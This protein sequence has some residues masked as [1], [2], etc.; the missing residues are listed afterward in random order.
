MTPTELVAYGAKKGLAALALTDHD[1]IDG[2][3]EA[4]EAGKRCGIEVIPGI[5]TTTVVD[6]CDVHIVGLFFDPRQPGIRSQVAEMAKSRDD[7]NYAMVRQLEEAGIDIH[8]ADFSR[9]EG[10]AIA[11]AHVAGILMERGYASNL[12]E[13]VAKYMARGTVGYVRRRTPKPA[14]VVEV[15]HQAGGLAIIAH[16]NQI[17]RKD[18]AHGEAVCRSIIEAGA[19]GLE[20]L[21]SEYDEVWRGRAEALRKEY[22]LLASGGSD[23]HG[24]FKPGL[25]LGCGYGELAVPLEFL[26]EMKKKLR[27]Q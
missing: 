8:W 9:W 4:L 25:D 21:Y 3:E 22:G 16:I 13:A 27:T 1:T 19:D 20:T 6:N 17:D 10:R 5:E 15:L 18:W 2:V 26:E 14:E 11:K 24:S 7:R 23:F 12:K